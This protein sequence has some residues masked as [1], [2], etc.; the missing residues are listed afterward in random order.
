M[1]S[2]TPESDFRNQK[3]GSIYSHQQIAD[4]SYHM[5]T[6]SQ[7]SQK[8]TDIIKACQKALSFPIGAVIVEETDNNGW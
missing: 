8:V 4:S 7:T 3:D 2:T 6:H 5:L 1:V